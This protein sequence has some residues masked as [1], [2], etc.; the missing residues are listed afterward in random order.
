MGWNRSIARSTSPGSGDVQAASA[1][2]SAHTSIAAVS[3]SPMARSKLGM[4]PRARTG[5]TR[6]S[7]T[8][9]N[10]V[11]TVGDAAVA[12]PSSGDAFR[13]LERMNLALG[14][15]PVAPATTRSPPPARAGAR[16]CS[17]ITW[18]MPSRL[19]ITDTPRP[20]PP[21][22]TALRTGCAESERRARPNIMRVTRRARSRHRASGTS[23]AHARQCTGRA[24]RPRRRYHH[25]AHGRAGRR[26]R[27]RSPRPTLR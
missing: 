2:A 21:A 26:S 17:R 9:Y 20:K 24:S 19:A 3:S 14:T 8:R 11:R 13:A 5:T 1:D 10:V 15:L 6:S 25:D 22:R 4:P 16:A 23:A 12:R 27:G 7:P 18:P